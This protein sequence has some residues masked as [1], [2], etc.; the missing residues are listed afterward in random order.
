[1]KFLN[2]LE[3]NVKVINPK[4]KIENERLKNK[5]FVLTGSL[6]TMARDEAK[7]KIRE[8]G[9]NVSGSVS[10]KTSYVVVGQEAGSNANRAQ[11]L[12]VK[13]ISEEEF[14]KMLK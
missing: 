1:L 5:I 7:S 2:K 13:L 14:I 10:S 12:G 3:N 6:K 8:L 11:K 4:Q 9:G